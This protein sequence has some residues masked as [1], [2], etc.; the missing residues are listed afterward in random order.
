MCKLG[1]SFFSPI[2]FI[3]EKKKT[4]QVVIIF[5]KKKV[6]FLSTDAKSLFYFNFFLD[7]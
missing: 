3:S 4:H 6:K 7:I 1:F 5:P 2:F